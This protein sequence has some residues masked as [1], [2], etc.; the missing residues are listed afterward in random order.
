MNVAF[1]LV[2]YTK[3]IR[4]NNTADF[5][6]LRLCLLISLEAQYIHKTLRYTSVS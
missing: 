3:Y 4:I 1:F 6:L 5:L 2:I